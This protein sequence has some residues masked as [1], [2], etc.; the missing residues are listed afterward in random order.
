MPYLLD[1]DVL[2]RAKNDHYPFDMVPAFWDWLLVANADG[3]V[4]S[5]HRVRDELVKGED[6]LAQWATDNTHF[7]LPADQATSDALTPVVTW[8]EAETRFMEA[9]RTRFMDGADLYLVAHALAHGFTVVTHEMA[10]PNARARVKIPDV[11]IGL[12]V[13]TCTPFEML[14]T[15]GARFVLG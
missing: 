4:H 8:I 5:I 9:A 15:Q 1:S 14:R 6:D 7:F 10:E 13:S 12:S 2:I 11:C 3:V